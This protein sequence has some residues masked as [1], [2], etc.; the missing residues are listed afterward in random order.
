M[1]NGFKNWVYITGLAV[2]MG[3]L[4]FACE[5]EQ[6]EEII[7][8]VEVSV[9]ALVIN[10][11]GMDPEGNTP[12]IDVES[13]VYW[14]ASVQ[15]D[16]ENEWLTIF[17]SAG[18]GDT[19]IELTATSNDSD[20]ERSATV[21]LETLSGKTVQI[22]ITQT[23]KNATVYYLVEDMGAETANMVDVNFFDNWTKTG[24]GSLFTRYTGVNGA[25]VDS[26]N[27]SE[28]Y[29]G[30]SGGNN[31]LLS[32]VNSTLI[33]GQVSTKEKEYFTLSF[34]VYAP[35][36]FDAEDLNLLISKNGDDWV[37]L[38][39]TRSAAAGWALLT[40]KFQ[41]SDLS[42]AYYK[43]ETTKPGVRVDDIVMLEDETKSGEPVVFQVIIDDGKPAGYVYY[44]EDF[45]WITV[46][47]FGGTA[48]NFPTNELG[49]NN[50]NINA[51]QQ[52]T[53]AKYGWTQELGATYMRE[54]LIKLG[55]TKV[56][57]DLISPP[58]SGIEQF[59]AVVVEVSFDVAMYSS[60]TGKV[61]D[62]DGIVIEVRNG[63][64]I[65]SQVYT[66][67]AF[68]VDYWLRT[69]EEQTE[70][71]KNFKATI[72]GA[73][74]NTQFRIR[75]GVE[76]SEQNRLNESNRFFFDNFKVTKLDADN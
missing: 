25:L 53:I 14:I 49:F 65:N 35:D 28:G 31:I 39:Y 37:E 64:T 46:E 26:S 22:L 10:N 63:G 68:D 67:Y 3:T 66:S 45:S 9:Q 76:N 20:E 33:W 51:E 24:I 32:E 18:T 13:N 16:E 62:L 72:Y 52:D 38:P 29:T 47:T 23:D 2:F 61:V 27:P 42:Y 73:T 5:P 59:K 7:P 40:S 6:G 11:M 70:P 12:S 1:K 36:A 4:F 43:L 41:V 48:A 19:R 15:Q 69:G 58:F 21:T 44:E 17:P 60:A 57:G 54:G 55:K 74:S 34:G 75:S 8:R 50:A 56:G 30:A 71:F